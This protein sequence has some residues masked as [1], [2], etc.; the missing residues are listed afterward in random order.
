MA[1][2]ETVLGHARAAGRP[3]LITY[4]TAGIRADWLD[5]LRVMIDAGADAV[6]I[7]LPFSD[8]MLD[9]PAIQQA[10]STAI[11]RGT[12]LASTLSQLRDLKDLDTP[13]IAMSYANHAYTRGLRRYCREL[14]GCG[15]SG[16]IIPDLPARE[17]GEYLAEAR[18]A[19]LDATLM[20]TPA[21]PDRQMRII[22]ERSRGFLYVMSVMNTTGQADE[23]DDDTRWAVAARSRKQSTRPVIIGFG[24]DTP[25]RAAA[26]ARHADG[27]I[28]ASAL[29]RRV[30]DGAPGAEIGRCVRE[31]RT[32][33]DHAR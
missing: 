9:G 13:L 20:V 16:T 2:V 19:G 27:V 6:E 4:V 23:R 5:L 8:P 3:A 30:M 26:A 21:T 25:E 24:I 18:D 12:T 22:A 32:A 15:V 7:G 29:M 1:A 11:S 14:A 28:V 10:S 31:I 33:I 17:A